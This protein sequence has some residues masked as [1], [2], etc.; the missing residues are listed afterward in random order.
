MTSI[1]KQKRRDCYLSTTESDP[2]V[3]ADLPVGRAAR[4]NQSTH[5][6]LL[7]PVNPSNAVPIRKASNGTAAMH[8]DVSKQRPFRHG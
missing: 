1:S 7:E 5:V 8:Q 3:G 4:A 6:R 2:A